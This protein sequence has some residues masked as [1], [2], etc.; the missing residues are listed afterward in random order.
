M[1]GPLTDGKP[2]P[3]GTLKMV[4]KDARK[5]REGIIGLDRYFERVSQAKRYGKV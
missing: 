3:L 5:C 2:V 4:M 1:V